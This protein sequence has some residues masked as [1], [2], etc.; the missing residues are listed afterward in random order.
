MHHSSSAAP[1]S[2]SARPPRDG[3]ASATGRAIC[4]PAS[5]RGHSPSSASHPSAALAAGAVPPSASSLE[6]SSA[7]SEMPAQAALSGQSSGAE[8]SSASEARALDPPRR[9]GTSLC[10]DLAP[11]FIVAGPLPGLPRPGTE[12][13][14]PD[15]SSVE[16]APL[17]VDGES[18]SA[19]SASAP[20]SL[21]VGRPGFSSS[22]AGSGGGPPHG[23]TV[24]TVPSV[25]GSRRRY[26]HALLQRSAA[27]MMF[28]KGVQSVEPQCLEYVSSW[29]ALRIGTIGR[30]AK[31]YANIRGT[32]A[33]NYF[34]VKQALF[35]VCPSSYAALFRTTGIEPVAGTQPKEVL[36]GAG[37]RGRRAREAPLAG[38][39][40]RNGLQGVACP[41]EEDEPV[42]TTEDSWLYRRLLGEPADFIAGEDAGAVGGVS[43]ALAPGPAA[44]DG[45]HDAHAA[46][47]RPDEAAF[48][49]LDNAAGQR[50]GAN[51]SP[52]ADLLSAGSAASPPDAASA[53]T[54][55]GA[56][57]TAGG[58][59]H[60][61]GGAD[62][63][64]PSPAVGPE[65]G[66]GGGTLPGGP[67]F[68]HLGLQGGGVGG[69][70]GPGGKSGTGRG[71]ATPLHVP[72]WLPQFPP[73]HLWE[74]TPTPCPPA[75]DAFTLDFKRQCA[76]MELQLHLP[77][78][79]L[80]QM[81]PPSVRRGDGAQ[82]RGRSDGE[83]DGLGAAG[84]DGDEPDGT[85]RPGG[86]KRRRA[87]QG[88][89]EGENGRLWGVSRD[90]AQTASA[91]PAREVD[92]V[93]R[94]DAEAE[95]GGVDRTDEEIKRK[96]KRKED[97][98]GKGKRKRMKQEDEVVEREAT[99]DGS[100]KN[101]FLS[102]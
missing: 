39:D 80:P 42:V 57:V 22:G 34:D 59:P 5:S 25:C 19:F 45:A 56:A 54:A 17:A 64:G 58:G 47:S 46:G 61:S 88:D 53:A 51:S 29:L 95:P 69:A 97:A 12:T 23:R 87:E 72:P 15:P 76:K 66:A 6:A 44:L 24:V 49:G 4:D 38:S 74:C 63:P 73:V 36:L 99:D 8:A 18:S 33:A 16:S 43:P 1:P 75:T 9:H 101:L 41:L 37:G 7:S 92:G 28:S 27:W 31:M 81:P 32:S 70:G 71:L 13:V 86:G 40:A 98:G 91:Q 14:L 2:G 77:Q 89:G 83:G 102:W 30:Q 82:W 94:G 100:R 21:T 35:D 93:R 65:P 55:G 68:P 50:G 79:Q 85:S 52:S 26:M 11:S 60:T 96:D 84:R 20:A 90:P 10:A 48:R 62:L 3:A 78:L 67:G